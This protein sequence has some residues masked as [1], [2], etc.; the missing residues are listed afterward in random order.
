MSTKPMQYEWHSFKQNGLPFLDSSPGMCE[1][2]RLK[3]I[4]M[5]CWALMQFAVCST[6][7]L[8]TLNMVTLSILT[9]NYLNIFGI[10]I[11]GKFHFTK[12]FSNM[13][14]DRA[15]W[16][17][18]SNFLN[19]R[20]HCSWTDHGRKFNPD[21]VHLFLSA[22]SSVYQKWTCSLLVHSLCNNIGSRVELLTDLFLH[23]I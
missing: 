5:G 14:N 21:W 12:M 2:E 20:S 11:N 3:P 16:S 23:K 7:V 19:H 6:T 8:S 13:P 17:N 22:P 4:W 9:T 15:M 10:V 1:G 18:R